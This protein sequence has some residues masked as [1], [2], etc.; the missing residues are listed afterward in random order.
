MNE[1]LC[2][3]WSIGEEDNRERKTEA[4]NRNKIKRKNLKAVF[5]FIKKTQE[6]MS[7]KEKAKKG[8]KS[9]SDMFLLSLVDNR[10]R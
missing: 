2:K 3:F 7:T 1:R 5:S 6:Q 9:S 10:N 8:N 4:R